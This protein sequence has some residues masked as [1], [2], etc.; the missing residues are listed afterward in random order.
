MS[1]TVHNGPRGRFDAREREFVRSAYPGIGP[2][3]IA[4]KLGRSKS[5][6]CALIKRMKDA[7]E[8]DA[9]R[10]NRESASQSA[11][12]SI[13]ESDGAQ[14]TLGRLRR[15]RALL[16]RHMRDA[17]PGQVARIASEYRAVVEEIDRIESREGGEA[18]DPFDN[19]ASAIASKLGKA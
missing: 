13:D 19:L 15:L 17:A 7:G 10:R 16:E 4:R 1:K 9:D 6:V 12:L 2:E 5:G 8:I 11:Q 18:D 14:D 3:T